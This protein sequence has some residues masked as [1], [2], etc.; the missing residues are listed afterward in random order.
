VG[1][2]KEVSFEN[3]INNRIKELKKIISYCERVK[4][5]LIFLEGIIEKEFDD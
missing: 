2:N 3:M 1:E 4:I 5:N